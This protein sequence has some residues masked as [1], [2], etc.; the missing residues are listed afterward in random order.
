MTLREGNAA[1]HVTRQTCVFDE[2]LGRATVD[3][4][5]K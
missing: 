4:S 5:K 3:P 1:P 2:E